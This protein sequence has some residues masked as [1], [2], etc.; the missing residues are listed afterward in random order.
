MSEKIN[1]EL[2]TSAIKQAQK[3]RKTHSGVIFHNDRSS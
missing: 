3:F 2:V 1:A